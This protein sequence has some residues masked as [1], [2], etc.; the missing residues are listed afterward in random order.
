MIRILHGDEHGVNT[1]LPEHLVQLPE[2]PAIHIVAGKNTI[3][4]AQEFDNR[5]HSCQTGNLLTGTKLSDTIHGQGGADLLQA[6]DELV[7]LCLS[8]SPD[9]YPDE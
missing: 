9:H 4:A 6:V 8:T 7:H 2:R 5:I 1:K 3:S